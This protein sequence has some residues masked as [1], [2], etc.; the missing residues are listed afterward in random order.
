MRV[1]LSRCFA[2]GCRADGRG[3]REQSGVD[4]VGCQ[5]L[6]AVTRI[7]ELTGAGRRGESDQGQLEQPSSV[8]HLGFLEL[9]AVAFQRTKQFFNSPPQPVEAYDFGGT[10]R[11]DGRDRGEQAPQEWRAFAV[12]V[13]LTRLDHGQG[14]IG[15]AGGSSPFQHAARQLRCGQPLS[16]VA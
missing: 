2:F 4:D 11:V 5:P 14:E 7:D 3:G 10:V 9:E 16:A 1:F 13:D 15:R 8:L 6:A 12:P